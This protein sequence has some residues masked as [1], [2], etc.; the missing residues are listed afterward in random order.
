MMAECA[1]SLSWCAVGAQPILVS[2]V[3]RSS[4]WRRDTVIARADA[5]IDW[6]FIQRMFNEV[7]LRVCRQVG[8]ICFDRERRLGTAHGDF[9]I[10]GHATTQG[11]R[12]VADIVFTRLKEA[13]PPPGR[14]RATTTRTH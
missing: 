8:E 2:Q 1:V 6:A 4:R 14:D 13:L 7:T 5:L 11:S 9:L 10:D 3:R 12:K